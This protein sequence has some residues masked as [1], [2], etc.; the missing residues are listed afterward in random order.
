M[1]RLLDKYAAKMVAAGLVEPGA[2]LLCGLDAETVWNRADPLC[3][4]L[5]QVLGGLEVNSLLYAVPAEPY[6]SLL[7]FEAAR[8]LKEGN[9]A[10]GATG[11]IRPEDGETRTFLHDVPAVGGFEPGA[12]IAALKRRKG[13]V[14]LD[15]TGSAVLTWGTVS[16]EQAFVTFSSIC[17]TCFVKFFGDYLEA[18]RAG[19]A[20]VEQQRVFAAAFTRTPPPAEEPPELRRGPFESAAEVRRAIAEAGRAVVEYRLVDSFFGNVSFRFRETLYISRTASSLDELDDELDPCP[21]DGSSCAGITASSELSAHLEIVK[22][23]DRRAV[24]HG[25]P[26]FTVILS[27]LCDKKADC[28]FA[29]RCHLECPEER[30]LKEEVP[31]VPGEVGT[32][33]HGLC[34]TLPPALRGRRAVAVRGHGLFTVGREDFNGAFAELLAVERFCREE[35]LRLVEAAA[36]AADKQG[37]N[38]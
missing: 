26:K 8:A 3:G 30:F 23:S 38:G 7:G 13:V 9:G 11:V 12:V 33:P 4:K 5:E 20:G 15:E 18:C 2:P 21:L 28:A 34:R 25:H 1:K 6:R 10:A 17:F 29:G 32:G 14:I 35:Y 27:L 19:A 36:G 16:P 24:L 22:T 37:G 31:V